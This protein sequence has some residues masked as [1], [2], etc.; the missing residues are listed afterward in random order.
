[1]TNAA[2]DAALSPDTDRNIA[3]AGYALLFAAIFVA[4]APALV[5]VA[6][7]YW[8]RGQA[9]TAVARHLGGQIRIFWIAFALSLAAG[10]CGLS[11][12]LIAMRDLWIAGLDF[13]AWDAVGMDWSSLRVETSAIVLAVLS[14]ALSAVTALWLLAASGLG[15]ARLMGE[16]DAAAPAPPSVDAPAHA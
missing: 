16:E 9:P 1:M 4:G 10:V 8:R 6:L 15:F 2:S 3:L 11:A 14:L 13:D 7:A 5:A 12:A